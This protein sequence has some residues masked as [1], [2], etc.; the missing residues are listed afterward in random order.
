MVEK[1]TAEAIAGAAR[2]AARV[3]AVRAVETVAGVKEL[4]A[5]A[6]ET[7]GVAKVVDSVVV[8]MDTEWGFSH[9]FLGENPPLTS[10]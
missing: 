5:T 2:A 4:E 3:A 6:G 8:S 10:L 7:M 1:A 9:S